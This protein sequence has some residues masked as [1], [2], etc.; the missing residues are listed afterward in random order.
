MCIFSHEMVLNKGLKVKLLCPPHFMPSFHIHSRTSHYG[1]FLGGWNIICTGDSEPVL[2]P[3]GT[4]F[5]AGKGEGEECP[6]P[7]SG[8]QAVPQ[9]PECPVSGENGTAR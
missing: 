2:N 5:L 3:V 7:Q 8:A 1:G 6:A 4:A 9:L